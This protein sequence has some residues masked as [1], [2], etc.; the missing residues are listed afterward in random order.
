MHLRRLMHKFLASTLIL[1]F[2]VSD[3]RVYAQG[4]I[5]LPAPGT[6]LALSPTFA[7]PLLKGI[8]V[9]RNDPFRF[10]FVLDSGTASTPEVDSRS[11]SGVASRLIKYFLAALTVPE[12]DLWVN[13]SP[14]EKD[15]IVPEEFGQTEMGRD[16]LAQDYILK[17]ITASVIYPDDKTGKEFWAKVYAEALKRYGTTDIPVDTF[18]KVWII[19]EKATVYENKDAAF[20]T[21]SKLKVMLESD[22]VAMSHQKD[23][24]E[25]SAPAGDVAMSPSTLPRELALDKKAPQDSDPMRST[26]ELAK[27][28]LREVVIPILEKEVNEG[29]NFATLRQVYNSLILATWYK[30]KVKASI[31]GQAYVDQKKVSGLGY[32]LPTQGHVAPFANV[33]PRTLPNELALDVKATQVSTEIQINLSPEQIWSQYVE[34][35]KKG[36]YN[37]I[38]EEI[39]PVTHE[40]LPR[41]YFSGGTDLDASQVFKIDLAELPA[42]DNATVVQTKFDMA[43]ENTLTPDEVKSLT[44]QFES[45]EVF[46]NQWHQWRQS[47]PDARVVFINRHPEST[48]NI[49]R[50]TQSNDGFSP[51]T[52]HGQ[53]QLKAFTEFLKPR[54]A[55]DRF[56]SSDSERAFDGLDLL[57]RAQGGRI[58]TL[59]TLREV[60]LFPIG[61]VPLA[62]ITKFMPDNWGSFLDDPLSF[63]LTQADSIKVKK[64][65]L[66]ILLN[67][68][69][70]QEQLNTAVSTHGMTIDLILME[71]FGVNYK[72]IKAVFKH[73]VEIPNMA[74]TVV[75]FEPA[76]G[77]W[78][79]LVKPD[80]SYLEEKI[81]ARIYHPATVDQERQRYNNMATEREKS[82]LKAGKITYLNDYY[83][84]PEV[85]AGL[86]DARLQE[87]IADFQKRNSLSDHAKNAGS[88]PGHDDTATDFLQ[89]RAIRDNLKPALDDNPFQHLKW[90]KNDSIDEIPQEILSGHNRD[91]SNYKVRKNWWAGV[92]ADLANILEEGL[93]KDEELK[94]RI[95]AFLQEYTANGFFARQRLTTQED[96]VK[97]NALIDEV[98]R[99]LEANGGDHS[100]AGGIDLNP[101]NIDMVTKNS[102]DEIKFNM[103]PAMLQ[104]L[105]NASGVIAVIVGIHSLDSVTAF[106]GVP[107]AAK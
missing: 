51:L 30:R 49:L 56:L 53:K 50:Q 61:G 45:L 47:H 35:F 90:L 1:A 66:A 83:P 59:P 73:F 97:V 105:Q 87:M 12:K 64:K 67:Q 28:I 15:R 80:N 96:I 29:K 57:A 20:V 106:M 26:H 7:P 23:M 104:R 101:S 88:T 34:A 18:N 32:A 31:M 10:D 37:Q 103:D 39:E 95:W 16:L 60:L 93:I 65:N 81:R 36:A 17:Q 75:A 33:S 5:Q 68:I 42:M 74:V 94:E 99:S 24:A 25:S 46:L 55:F 27:N 43:M 48:S 62:Q 3:V 40:V 22:Y 100:Q 69:A 63:G 72:K 8:K 44:P 107:A 76:V 2:L 13:L 92:L 6:R 41:R 38:K 78:Q 71:M 21:E 91:K 86:T 70:H 89:K 4:V 52:A 19:P 84:N 82:R 11:T 77:H 85:V 54:I 79:L 58:E 98:L 9:Y 102:G 14:Y